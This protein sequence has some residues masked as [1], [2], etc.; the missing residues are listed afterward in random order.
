MFDR[1]N[2]VSHAHASAINP[3]SSKG[4]ATSNTNITE[5]V[6]KSPKHKRKDELVMERCMDEMRDTS[7][8]FIDSL[9][10]SDEMKMNLLMSIQ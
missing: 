10:A 6:S 7:K 9:K 1:A 5:S 2:E 3:D 8:S 4:T